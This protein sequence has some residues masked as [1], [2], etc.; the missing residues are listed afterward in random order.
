MSK[1]QRLYIL[2]AF[3]IILHM[4]F[5]NA[6]FAAENFSVSDFHDHSSLYNQQHTD[7]V[8]ENLPD[9]LI[10]VQTQNAVQERDTLIR[11]TILPETDTIITDVETELTVEP[12]TIQAETQQA[13]SPPP[14]ARPVQ[15][16][17]TETYR[18]AFDRKKA[19]WV[20]WDSLLVARADQ[21]VSR[22]FSAREHFG[23]HSL[24]PTTIQPEPT[25][26]SRSPSKDILTLWI[27]LSLIMI[28][29]TRYLFPLRFKE[30]FLASFTGRYFNQLDREGGL[31]NNWASFFL[32]LNF[33]LVFSLLIYLSMEKW[34]NFSAIENIPFMLIISY[35]LI[36]ITTFYLI[37]YVLVFFIAWVFKT[38]P[39]TESYF[40][41]ILLINQSTGII[42]LPVL[43]I[44]IYN[45][46]LNLMVSAWVL[47]ILINLFKIIRGA[48]LGY[49]TLDFSPYYLILYL[50]AIE[51]APLILIIKLTII[52]LTP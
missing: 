23:P 44:S 2:S 30:N 1:K 27:I 29:I 36:A 32:F 11:D 4:M 46:G 40:L 13:P 49:K 52:G 45:P 8:P 35:I 42:L 34:G 19:Y 28:G 7:T 17:R 33:L 25:Y 16:V 47:L 37:K 50:C 5:L 3:F 38:K 43:V 51:F 9:T 10:P 18:T 20:E 22:V 39:A 26:I 31:M 48:Y 21:V 41:N 6:T 15:P 14:V 12:D 24:E